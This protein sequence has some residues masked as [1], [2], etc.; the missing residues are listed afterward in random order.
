MV[1]CI[2]DRHDDDNLQLLD[3]V[4]V[5]QEIDPADSLLDATDPIDVFD[6]VRP[7]QKSF[8]E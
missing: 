6:E 3:Y 2:D 5:H 1:S 4:D 8:S 7:D